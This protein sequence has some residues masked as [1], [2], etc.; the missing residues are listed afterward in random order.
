[1]SEHLQHEAAYRGN[2]NVLKQRSEKKIIVM[3]AGA[4]GSFLV[5]QLA[6]QGY[7]QI[8]VVDRDKVER[9]NFG[10]QLYGKTDIGRAKSIQCA[11]N[12]M[13]RI[14]VKVSPIV[15]NIND[16]NVNPIVSGSDLIVDLFDN[17]SARRV[18]KQASERWNIPCLHAG[19]GAIG[20]FEVLWNE[21]YRIPDSDAGDG[22]DAPCD[23]PLASNLVTLCVGA[24]AEVINR[25]VDEGQKI[26]IDFWLHKMKMGEL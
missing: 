4:L 17:P 18:L 7:E 21:N 16:G 23:Y 3:G 25:Y 22:L 20:Y 2:M 10:T 24:V 26:Q 9:T 1:M 13:K 8:T 11:Q 15:K 12:V 14:G 6:R 5:D 19:M